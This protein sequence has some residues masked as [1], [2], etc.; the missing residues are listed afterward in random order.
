MHKVSLGVVTLSAAKGEMIMHVSRSSDG[1][2]SVACSH[3]L[4][5]SSCV[6][7]VPRQVLDEDLNSCAS[8]AN[9]IFYPCMEATGKLTSVTL[10]YTHIY[11]YIPTKYVT[12][13]TLTH[14][15]H[16]QNSTSQSHSNV[17]VTTACRGY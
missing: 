10:M 3:V 8:A 1:D 4:S 13:A 11:P 12:H 16:T 14:T 5:L 17:S 7:T 6:I 9:Q 15:P 2:I